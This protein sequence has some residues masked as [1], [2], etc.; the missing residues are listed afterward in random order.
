MSNSYYMSFFVFQNLAALME[1]RERKKKKE[2]KKKKSC[3]IIS[4]RIVCLKK[5][6]LPILEKLFRPGRRRG[7]GRG[8]SVFEIWSMRSFLLGFGFLKCL[9]MS[10][11]HTHKPNWHFK[12]KKGPV[13]VDQ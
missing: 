13:L 5:N 12:K 1:T 10:E 7:G 2:K 3:A 4:Y 11:W 6:L 9:H 8:Q